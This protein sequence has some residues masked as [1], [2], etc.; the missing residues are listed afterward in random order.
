MK[1]IK[2][3]LLLTIMLLT[4]YSCDNSSEVKPS[5][6]DNEVK[7]K[8]NGLKDYG[9]DLFSKADYLPVMKNHVYSE[10]QSSYSRNGNNVDGFGMNG[11]VSGEVN[12]IAL[13]RP[14]LELYQPGIVYR[15]WFTTWENIKF[16]R[17]YI[18]GSEKPVYSH[19]LYELTSGENDPFVKPLVFNQDESS[20]GFVSYVPIIFK[21]SIRIVGSGNFY[22][23]INY[24]KYPQGYELEY[25]NYEEQLP[26]ATKIL[27]NV[28]ED[29]KITNND[30]KTELKFD[31]NR[32]SS[33]TLYET[34]E[35][36]TITSLKVRFPNL[37]VNEFDRTSITDKGYRLFNN[38]SM[39]FD[40]T[41]NQTGQHL[42]YFRGV[43]TNENQQAT[44]TVN[45]VNVGNLRFRP[46]RIDGFEWK[47]SNYF[48]DSYI[49]IPSAVIANKLLIT[50]KS[51]TRSIDIYNARLV[52][53][54][55][56]IDKIDFRNDN[57]QSKHNYSSSKILSP[58]ETTLE[59][60]PNQ[61]ISDETWSKIFQEEDL[62]NN[63]YI[64]ITYPDVEDIAVLAPISS[65]F[66]FGEYGMFKTLGIMVGLNKD[67]WMY[68]YYPM[69]FEKGIK[70]ELVNH[71]DIS[72]A[73]LEGEV[74][75]E[76]NQFS[77]GE[78]GYFKVKF[79]SN[80]QGTSSSLV[81][82]QPMQFL[83]VSGSGHIAGITHSMSGLYFGAH[84]RFYLEGDE[85]IYVDGSL[86]HSFHGT[87]TEDFYNGGWYFK[88]GVQNTPLFGSTNHNYRDD[89]NRTVMTRTFLTDPIYFRN[90]I[91][92]KME[93]GGVNDRAD[94]NVKTAV[95]YYHLQE[96]AMQLND[97]LNISSDSSISE[98]NY[99]NSNSVMI[100]TK[101]LTY[102]GTYIR[103]YTSYLKAYEVSQ[104]SSFKMN[105][106]PNNNGVVLR[107]EYVLE[108][109]NQ[110]ANVYVDNQLVGKWQ[111]SFRNALGLFVRQDDFYILEKFTTGKSNI[112]I[113]I[114]VVP[115]DDSKVWTESYYE[116]YSI[117]KED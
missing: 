40:M 33:Y 14:L 104:E 30:A 50:I 106:N 39:S 10:Q 31:L 65:F 64:K 22:Y 75:T 82:G 35:K 9:L 18:D 52:K 42:L 95:Y 94:S 87:G 55:D 16:I 43:L 58:L 105:I 85:Q 27:E 116:I 80:V 66:G 97:M 34:N 48:Y 28:G 38:E 37:S 53:V 13:M 96:E 61:L 72:F 23:N 108:H 56:E 73:N 89:R 98:H 67:G 44:V 79:T 84:S 62:I 76:T 115:N 114:E 60:D 2:L 6:T 111:S 90:G 101:E 17:I 100:N 69:P 5:L 29:P 81:N 88:N 77:K 47:D 107:R 86:S 68:S 15:M 93:H 71:S 3:T 103:R 11:N 112:T 45:G 57:S 19:D 109:I 26:M 70:I 54:T 99:Q 41:T 92:F 4:I 110:S 74:S 8:L 1:K 83:N 20:G 51:T 113:T 91:E 102:E 36:K 49:I 24:Q 12:E 32:G 46:R 59:Y 117:I 78:Y 7:E 21:E 63:I 25:D